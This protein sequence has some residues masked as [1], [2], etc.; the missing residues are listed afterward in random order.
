MD[1]F[2]IVT[3]ELLAHEQFGLW[4]QALI[5]LAEKLSPSEYVLLD[6]GYKLALRST[7][8]AVPDC[9]LTWDVHADGRTVQINLADSAGDA[10]VLSAIGESRNTPG[11]FAVLRQG[12]LQAN[13]ENIRQISGGDF[14]YAFQKLPVGASGAFGAKG[15]EWFLVCNLS[16]TAH[17]IAK[18]TGDFAERCANVRKKFSRGLVLK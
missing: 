11:Q 18:E 5:S 15:R 7:K 14:R 6:Y 16:G 17:Q 12:R 10:N 8:H 9:D 2:K 13:R 1:T 4:H 3:S